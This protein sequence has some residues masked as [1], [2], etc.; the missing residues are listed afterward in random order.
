MRFGI[1]DVRNTPLVLKLVSA[2]S[3]QTLFLHR[4]G[5]VESGGFHFNTKLARGDWG[6]KESE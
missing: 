1:G 3:T 6:E 4:E 2:N 5:R